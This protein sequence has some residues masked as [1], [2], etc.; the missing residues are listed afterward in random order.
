[1]VTLLPKTLEQIY[2]HA[3]SVFPDE[4]CGIILH[5]GTQ[6]YVRPCRNIQ[7]DLHK[8]DPVAYPRDAKTAYVMHPDDLITIHK[9]SET[10]NLPIKA[11]YHSHPNHEAYFSDKD[12]SDA[13]WGEDPIYPGVAYL[14]IS[15][16]DATVRVVKAFTWDD[17]KSDFSE[18]SFHTSPSGALQHTS[19]KVR[20]TFPPEK[21]TEPI[22]YNIGQQFRVITNIRRA[23]VTE[24][25]GW[26]MLELLG[27]SDEIERAIDYLKNI[28]VQ[29]ELVE[30]DVVQ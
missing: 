17:A 10:E 15:I 24:D 18:V 3:E 21:I 11:F 23:N 13:M 30:G 6:E 14:V 9:E 12:R 7:N 20:L 29:V 26:V 22:I 25:A 16:Y 19:L 4:C 5:N 1:M 8:D 28:K 2:T 27:A